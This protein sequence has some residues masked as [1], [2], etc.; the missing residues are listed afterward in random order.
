VIAGSEASPS[1]SA[2]L[3]PPQISIRV[4]CQLV[5]SPQF[6]VALIERESVRAATNSYSSPF[7][8][9]RARDESHIPFGVGPRMVRKM[10]LH[11][12]A[13]FYYEPYLAITGFGPLLCPWA[14][15]YTWPQG[16]PRE[17]SLQWI[18]LALLAIAPGGAQVQSPYPMSP[19][20]GGQYPQQGQYPP[21]QYPQGQYP[22]P[23]QYPPG[24]YPPGTVGLPGGVGIPMPRLPGRKP[25]DTSNPNS[26]NTRVALRA[27]D[28]TLYEL[29][30]KDL[31]SKPPTTRF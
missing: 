18:L 8:G 30:E 17:R 1:R 15:L 10:D 28:G 5:V 26:N 9:L 14:L 16:V 13:G 4:V 22:P 25:K 27:V 29:G 20:P 11:Q 2:P 23:G 24:Q 6:R 31:I 19:Y 21:N 12:L 7:G 3:R